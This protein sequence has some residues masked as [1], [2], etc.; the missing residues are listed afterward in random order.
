MVAPVRRITE[1]G[2]M[3]A[4]LVI[5]VILILVLAIVVAGGLTCS[6]SIS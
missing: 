6:I 5:A 1:E 2:V 3:K 4:C